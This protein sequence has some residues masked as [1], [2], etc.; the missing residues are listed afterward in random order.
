MGIKTRYT[1]QVICDRCDTTENFV[2]EEE[3]APVPDTWAE[4]TRRRWKEGQ[5]DATRGNEEFFALL[6]PGCLAMTDIKW[7]NSFDFYYEG[8]KE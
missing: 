6:C 1:H 5:S 2:T 7:K 4:L 8:E 3:R